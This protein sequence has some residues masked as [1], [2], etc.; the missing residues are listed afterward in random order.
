MQA[1]VRDVCSNAGSERDSTQAKD[2]TPSVGSREW[3]NDQ[4][5]DA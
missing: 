1:K 4:V 2:P 5:M 3:N